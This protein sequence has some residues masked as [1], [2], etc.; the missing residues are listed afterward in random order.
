MFYE[1]LVAASYDIRRDARQDAQTILLVYDDKRDWLNIHTHLQR[2]RLHR[3]EQP[4]QA[5]QIGDDFR[6]A[7]F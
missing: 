1:Q 4:N 6:G 7:E 3:E 2:S 5:F